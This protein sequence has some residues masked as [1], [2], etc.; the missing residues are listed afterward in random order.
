MEIIQSTESFWLTV[1]VYAWYNFVHLN[2]LYTQ[3]WMW[4][5]HHQARQNSPLLYVKWQVR[6]TG[7]VMKCQSKTK[8]ASK[9]VLLIWKKYDIVSAIRWFVDT[10]TKDLLWPKSRTFTVSLPLQGKVLNRSK[11]RRLQTAAEWHKIRF[12]FLAF[13]TSPGFV[14]GLLSGLRSH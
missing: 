7:P 10:D 2:W 6:G 9:Q 3:S 8:K 11:Q 13:L 4:P 14:W 5:T 1:M 12:F